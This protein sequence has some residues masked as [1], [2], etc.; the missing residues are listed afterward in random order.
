MLQ[1][2][3]SPRICIGRRSIGFLGLTYLPSPLFLSR[4]D[5]RRHQDLGEYYQSPHNFD[6]EMA[7]TVLNIDFLLTACAH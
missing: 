3:Y 5:K 6:N 4:S 1:E 7:V 2:L